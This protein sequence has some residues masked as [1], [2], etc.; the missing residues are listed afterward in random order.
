L[1]PIQ[2]A[3]HDREGEG[4]GAGVRVHRDATGEVVHAEVVDDPAADVAA[5]IGAEREH[6]V[7]DGEVAEGDP[8][9]GEEQPGAELHAALD[10]AG[11]DRGGEAS[12]HEV[13]RGRRDRRGDALVGSAREDRLDAEGLG[14]VADDAEAADRIAEDQAVA[15]QHEQYRADGE[16]AEHDHDAV[17]HVLRARHAAVVEREP[18]HHEHHEHAGHEDPHGVDR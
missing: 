3:E 16:A 4:R 12:K 6:P 17:E 5:V 18:R 8:E 11:D 15:E 10:R 9:A 14:R 7:G 1:K 2:P 13:E